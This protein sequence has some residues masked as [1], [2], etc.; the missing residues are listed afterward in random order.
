MPS[1]LNLLQ[2]DNYLPGKGCSVDETLAALTT[3]HVSLIMCTQVGWLPNALSHSKRSRQFASPCLFLKGWF[4][5]CNWCNKSWP[6]TK[7]SLNLNTLK[8]NQPNLHIAKKTT[9]GISFWSNWQCQ[10]EK[11]ANIPKRESATRR[12]CF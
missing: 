2:K 4:N 8:R 6:R 5:L 12:C 1:L 3:A 9:F 10:E 11:S 7:F